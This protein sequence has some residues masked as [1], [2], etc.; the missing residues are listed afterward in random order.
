MDLLERLTKL[1]NELD[2]K[3]LFEEADQIDL[4][5]TEAAKKKDFHAHKEKGVKKLVHKAP[6]EW[7][8]EELAKVMKGNP[9]YS[10]ERADRVVAD[11]WDHKLSDAKRQEIYKRYGKHHN[12][13]K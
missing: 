13:N 10:K 4:L 8:K 9:S 1:A 2:A 12:P 6:K 11:I 5:I 3:G 7:F